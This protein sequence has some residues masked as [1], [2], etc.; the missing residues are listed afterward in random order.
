MFLNLLKKLVALLEG[1]EENNTRLLD[2][3]T[4]NGYDV[5]YVRRKQKCKHCSSEFEILSHK[6]IKEVKTGEN[7]YLRGWWYFYAPSV[8]CPACWSR[9]Y[10][11]FY[12]PVKECWGYCI[13]LNSKPARAYRI[14]EDSDIEIKSDE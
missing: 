1:G 11:N 4:M 9:H 5:R 14:L 8:K 12:S 6:S 2:D 10:M 3:K 7:Q 13:T